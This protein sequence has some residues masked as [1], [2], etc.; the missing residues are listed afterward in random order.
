MSVV[1]QAD[2]AE[3]TTNLTDHHRQVD[4]LSGALRLSIS[5]LRHE[6][7]H[8]GSMVAIGLDIDDVPW[9]TAT[10]QAQAT[11]LRVRT[12]SRVEGARS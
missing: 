10:E 2:L 5:A 9:S 1:G 4:V 11:R 12:L 3:L 7:S 6:L 8:A